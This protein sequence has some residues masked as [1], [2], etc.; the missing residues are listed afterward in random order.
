MSRKVE[1]EVEFAP[2]LGEV[3][4][5]STSSNQEPAIAGA[6]LGMPCVSV[7]RT[8]NTMRERFWPGWSPSPSRGSGCVMEPNVGQYVE[9][10]AE[11]TR[12]NEDIDTPQTQNSD[13]LPPPNLKLNPSPITSYPSPTTSLMQA[14]KDSNGGKHVARRQTLSWVKEGRGG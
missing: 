5:L 1:S 10:C 7:E 6:L 3:A 14:V 8:S 4:R 12:T 9:G 13:D 2:V 11:Y